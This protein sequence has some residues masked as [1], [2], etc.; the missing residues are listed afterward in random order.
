M[1]SK[2]R[3]VR[4]A[5]AMLTIG[6][7]G[8]ALAG[9]STT[10]GGGGGDDQTL[11]VGT[12]G[13]TGMLAVI[14]K[15]EADNP[16]VT[17]T[18]QDSPDAYQQVTATQ[19]T[20]GTAPDVMQVFP[21]T[22]NNV[23]VKI[24][25]DKGFFADLSSE[26]WVASLPDAAKDL[27]T[28]ND[29]EVVAVPMTFS[30]IGALYNTNALAE[31]GLSE[32][33]T[34]SE[35][36]QFCSDA[37]AAGKVAYGLGLS[38]AWTTQL[39]PYAL[40]ATLVYADDPDFAEQQADGTASF[41][42]SKWKEAFQKYLDMDAAGCFNPSPNGTSYQQ[43]RD[44]IVAGTTLATVTVAAESKAIA[45][46]GGSDLVLDLQAFPATDDAAGTYLSATV[47]PSFAVNA[48]AGNQDL[49]KKFVAYLAEPETQ[50]TY[51]DAYGD[52]AALPGD[53]TQDS[54]VSQMAAE[55]IAKNQI[56]TWPDQLWPSTTI[57]PAVFDGVQGLFAGSVDIQTVLK[58]MDD[59][60][61]EGASQ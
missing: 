30:S 37:T 45:A 52:T 55:F 34:W 5:A 8:A 46:T 32:P 35:V 26:E 11:T 57:Q 23:S 24:A 6:A 17:V 44:A 28:T 7:V 27:L 2:T 51:A 61:A 54:Q 16:G 20:G 50:I 59:A 1:S 60:F 3:P 29:G 48:K 15:F 49:A 22:G 38:D 9:C 18:I 13:N 36:L 33:T 39:I 14:D 58:N 10:V 43:V 53:L 42:D 21:G 31:A 40:V 4:V 56:S 12:N 19:L 47:G 41:S 25:G